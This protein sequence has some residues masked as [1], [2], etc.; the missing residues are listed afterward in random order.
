MARAKSL[1]ASVTTAE[2]DALIAVITEAR[3]AAGATR[4]GLSKKLG[5]SLPYIRKI[6]TK[7]RRLDAVEMLQI[8]AALELDPVEL[9]R[10]FVERTRT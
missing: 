8:A 4:E 5:Q 10:R 7:V 6:E 3:I 2:Y 1:V 9:Y